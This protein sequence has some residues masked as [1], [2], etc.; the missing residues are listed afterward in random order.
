[1]N[2]GN[3]PR[4]RSVFS[5]I[6]P[7][8]LMAATIGVFVWLIVSQF[9]GGGETWSVSD[10]DRNIGYVLND[11]GTEYK[12]YDV[13]SYSQADKKIISANASQNYRAVT[14]SGTYL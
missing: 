14:V 10:I 11:E 7:Y 5:Y 9:S 8:L 1:M 3:A 13:T 2:D 6:L 4:K 12:Q